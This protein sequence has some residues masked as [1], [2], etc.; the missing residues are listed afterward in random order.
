ME[1]E[2]IN[3]FELYILKEILKAILNYASEDLLTQIIY[4]CITKT[5]SAT[6]KT[7]LLCFFQ[8]N[9]QLQTKSYK[10]QQ[11]GLVFK[12]TIWIA[13]YM[14]ESKKIAMKQNQILSTLII[15]GFIVL[16]YATANIN[17]VNAQNMSSNMTRTNMT[18]PG[19][20]TNAGNVTN[21]TMA[22]NLNGP[23]SV[24]NTSSPMN[25]GS[26]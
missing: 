18:S 25:T 19:N 24:G 2:D 23:G 26:W 6:L 13:F 3:V 1:D 20:M 21:T 22:G 10:M 11:S 8:S 15:L 17:I 12:F 7:M 14:N 5:G 9:I 16:S 4:S